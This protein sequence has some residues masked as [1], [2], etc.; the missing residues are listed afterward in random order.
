MGGPAPI[1]RHPGSYTP[2]IKTAVSIPDQLF[3]R[4]DALARQLGKSRSQ[5]YREALLEYVARR[6]P[7]WVTQALDEVIEATD[8]DQDPW[9]DA[10][11]RRALERSEW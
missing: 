4:A 11:G 3:E 7:G 6:E 1:R 2:G 9:L 5:L 8:A 10:A